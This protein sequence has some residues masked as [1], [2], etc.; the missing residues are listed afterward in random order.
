M[1]RNVFIQASLEKSIWSAI[2]VKRTRV[3]LIAVLMSV[4]LASI[5][6]TQ[7][8]TYAASLSEVPTQTNPW[9]V[10]LDGNGNIWFSEFSANKIGF[11]NTTTHTFV[12]TTIPSADASP[13]GITT[14]PNGKIWFAENDLSKIGTFTPTTTGHITIAEHAI[15]TFSPHLITADKAGN[16]WYSQGFSGV[17]G[18]YVP[19]T[20][21]HKDF[22]GSN[23]I[24][25]NP[26]N[27]P[28]TH[29]SGISTDS[30]GMVWFDDSL[31][32]RVGYLNPQTGSV[33]AIRLSNTS[34]HPHD[35][36]IVDGSNNVWFTEL[37]AN[38]LGKIP[39]GSF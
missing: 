18:E 25:P 13:Y 23:G 34:A 16:I 5:F 30:H 9:G 38:K 39:A 21:M 12:E 1:T 22:Q 14:A 2:T 33:K 28:G 24:C 37:Y 29:I 32:A 36:L 35:G 17:I 19:N 7:Q 4:L 26:N 31:D 8:V 27:C 10:T 3:V 15:N 6:A 20:G 11:F